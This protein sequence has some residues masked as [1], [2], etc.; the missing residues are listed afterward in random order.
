VPDELITAL[1]RLLAYS[2]AMPHPDRV[3]DV[4]Q[5]LGWLEDQDSE[6]GMREAMRRIREAIL[7]AHLAQPGAYW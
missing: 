3:K 2:D 6:D 1:M 5:I 7:V 4:E